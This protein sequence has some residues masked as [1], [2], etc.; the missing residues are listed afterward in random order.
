[1][2]I[3]ENRRRFVEI[4]DR[5]LHTIWQ[6]GPVWATLNGIHEY[7]HTLGD[8]SADGFCRCAR[9]FKAYVEALQSEVNPDLLDPEEATDYHVALSLASSSLIAL[10]SQRLWMSDPSLYASTAIWGC[11]GLLTRDFA[12]YE[13][14]LRL[15]LDRMREIP[16]ALML[17]RGNISHPPSVFVQAALE[18]TQA[19]LSFFRNAVPRIAESAPVLHSELLAANDA[20]AS[21][22][23]AYEE[24]LRKAVLPNA[25]GDFA[26]GCDVYQQLLLAEHWLTYS[27]NDLVLLGERVLS[28][29]IEQ[30]KEVA[31]SIDPS[32][33]WQEL[34]ESLKKDHPPKDGLV[35]AYREAMESARDFVVER[36]LV[37]ILPTEHLEVSETPEFE[38][39]MLPYAAYFPPAPFEAGR[40]ALLWVT[41][42]DGSLPEDRQQ[43]QLLGHCT[44]TI[45]M[46]ALHEGY[47]GHHVQLTR[48]F[49][50]PSAL[51]RQALS[52]LTVEGWALYCER[53]MHEQ[54]FYSDPRVRLFQLKGLLW[55]AC[56]VIIDVG[57]HAGDMTLDDAVRMLVEVARLEEV[58]A[59]TEV[60]RYTITPTQPMSYVIGKLLILDLRDQMKQRLGGSFDLKAFHDRL[61]D[62]GSIPL[63]LILQKMLS[64]TARER[65]AP[66]RRSA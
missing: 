49:D 13:E 3:D 39:P 23:E 51:R 44:Y 54:G 62:C 42:I 59:L 37:T 43:A 41:P 47:P 5:I 56:R 27:P 34:V 31:G 9:T 26:A 20:A 12:P 53:M 6:S 21:A 1:M 46:I 50:S 55:R 35:Q 30:I 32:V 61:L 29:T 22:F 17:S 52:N 60:R 45:P 58:N 28:E 38:R 57:L 11:F 10:D 7:D 40:D 48:A 2:H 36:D 33:T 15:M 25:D 19:G 18:V 16:D 14:R 66:L 64:E 8:L 63:P 4:A 24:W 65:P